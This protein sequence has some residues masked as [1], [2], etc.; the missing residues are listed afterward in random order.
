MDTARALP[1]HSGLRAYVTP[2]IIVCLGIWMSVYSFTTARGRAAKQ[3][4]SIFAESARKDVARLSGHLATHEI[5]LRSLRAF[6]EGSEYVSRKEFQDF[7]NIV[8]SGLTDVDALMW[9]P[10]VAAGE[11]DAVER[12]AAASGVLGFEIISLGE[13]G[14]PVRADD[15]VEYFPILYISPMAGNQSRLGMDW[16]EVP[17]LRLGLDRARDGD[18]PVTVRFPPGAW[19]DE[20]APVLATI[21]PVYRKGTWIQSMDNRRTYLEGFLVEVYEPDRILGMGAL[22]GDS[23]AAGL[24]IA[25][26]RDDTSGAVIY[27]NGVVPSVMTAPDGDM[28]FPEIDGALHGVATLGVGRAAWTVF[29][30]PG[31]EL[32]S[33][34]KGWSSWLLLFTG[35][36]LTG[37][38]ATYLVIVQRSSAEIAWYADELQVT[39][40]ELERRLSEYLIAEKTLN[41]SERYLKVIFD[42]VSTGMLVIDPE[43]HTIV[44]ANMAAA[45]LVGVRKEHL[46]GRGCQGL[47][48]NTES[49]G[50]PVTDRGEILDNSESTFLNAS[51]EEVPCLRTVVPITLKGKK[52]LLDCIVDISS[53]KRAQAAAER[54]S[55]KLSAMISGME[56]GVV[57]ADA[58]NV[59]TGV[60]DFFCRFVGK[61][62]D[63]ILGRHIE[64]LHSGRILDHVKGLLQGFRSNVH[65]EPFT[66]QRQLGGAE[67]LLRIQ[68]IYRGGDYDG[69]LLNVIDVSKLVGARRQAEEATR[70]KSEFLAN[71]SHEIRTPMTAIMGYADLL[72]GPGL[73]DKDRLDYLDIIRRNGAHLLALIND[74]LDLSKIEAGRL[75]IEKDS[76]DLL[77]ML[78]DVASTMRVRARERDTELRTEFPTS[79]PKTIMTDRSRLHQVLV[80]LV[81]NAVKF[82]KGG[83]V[84]V[85]TS[86][87][88]E[89]HGEGPAVRIEVIDTGI[90]VS[91]ERLPRLFEPFVQADASTSREYG[92]T[93]LGLT[94]SAR[95][96]GLLG[97]EISA[98]SEPGKGSTFAVT[99]PTGDLE[100]V[101]VIETPSES[102]IEARADLGP[103]VVDPD[104]LKGLRILVAEDGP[105]NQRLI[106]T[107][108]SNAGGLV[109]LVEDGSAAVDA[110]ANGVFDVVLMD[111]Q[112]PTMDGYEA[113]RT[114]RARGYKIP[115]LAL[116]AH[117]MSADRDKCMAAGCDDH[118]TKPINQQKLITKVVRWARNHGAPEDGRLVTGV[119]DRDDG[120]VISHVERV[121]SEYADDPA[122]AGILEV[123]V[124]GLTG[125]VHAMKDHLANGNLDELERLA[126]QLKGAGGSYG[127]PIITEAAAGIEAACQK[128]DKEAV[129]RGIDLLERLCGAITA[130][131][132]KTT[133]SPAGV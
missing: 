11:R 122:L 14:L 70:A 93:G 66:L 71:M 46:V 98:A 57:F 109:T 37:G 114:L 59:I 55:A 62:G 73:D 85:R 131:F 101:E 78:A 103:A 82:T 105:D 129:P 26:I 54:E 43:S 116:T 23:H 51:G 39:Q 19:G 24:M 6:Y 25:M 18:R 69:V 104:A 121:V 27:E 5:V 118:L 106:K 64:A 45:G 95:I 7:T 65:S 89:W 127:Y 84:T 68:P 10:R 44:D 130:G 94:I 108:L 111:L 72:T 9:L 124:T 100:G 119:Q 99:V 4:K 117:A 41:E 8:L 125:K 60:N 90:G 74:I 126:H 30:T 52:H 113:T 112:M 38:I 132:E 48:C 35:L 102:L 2:A 83:S 87:L 75:L 107:V 53:Q 16:G 77:A 88:S 33:L 20:P 32:A 81:G 86:V 21:L 110:V 97:G 128:G 31:A 42:T 61:D 1:K 50:C 115:I 15:R 92:G 34:S 13:Q 63:E 123:F 29:S 133:K 58:Q 47:V 17:E 67:V 49:G 76:S 56:E 80:N 22:P 12:E 28:V 40:T 91:K 96:M 120:E 3:K 79:L 36:A